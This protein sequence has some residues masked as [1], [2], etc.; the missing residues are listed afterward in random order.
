VAS[1]NAG[2]GL[3]ALT[4][5]RSPL[6][7]VSDD[8]VARLSFA[9][10]SGGLSLHELAVLPPGVEARDRARLEELRGRIAALAVAAV[11]LGPGRLLAEAELL[12]DQKSRYG[13]AQAF[14]N[15]DKL[16]AIGRD[17]EAR[18]MSSAEFVLRLQRSCAEEP[19]EE[20]APAIDELDLSAVRMMT[21]HQAKGLQFPVVIVP[22]CGGSGREY[23]SVARYVRG[24]GLALRVRGPDGRWYSSQAYKEVADEARRRDTADHLRLLYVASTRARDRLIFS[25]EKVRGA[26]G[27]VWRELIDELADRLLTP[28]PSAPAQAARSASVAS[29]DSLRRCR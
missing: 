4:V 25:G 18:G 1:V 24:R 23:Y 13:D 8:T 3:A 28:T 17:W 16:T 9:R 10:R 27:P 19:R 6:C 5:L 12:F 11:S 29:D 15:L 14:A 26:R 2:D 20:L 22:E 21:V 7:G